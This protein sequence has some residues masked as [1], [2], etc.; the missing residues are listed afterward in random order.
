[1]RTSRPHTSL[2]HTRNRRLLPPGLHRAR[3]STKRTRRK[4]ASIVG[5]TVLV[6][7]VAAATYTALDAYHAGNE[8]RQAMPLA[9]DIK[10]AALAGDTEG[11]DE[12]ITELAQHTG[13][14]REYLHGPHWTIAAKLPFI[15]D[16]IEAVQTVASAVDDLASGPLSDLAT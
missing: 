15:G 3:V 5:S 14:A 8:L 9:G 12:R 2:P 11:L 6:A 1:P 4:V 13:A 10:T 16:D 7:G